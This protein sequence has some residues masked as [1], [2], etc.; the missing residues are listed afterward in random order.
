[1]CH[2]QEL[3]LLV[4][5]EG[6]TPTKKPCGIRKRRKREVGT[7]SGCGDG[8][9]GD[10]QDGDGASAKKPCGRPKTG[11]VTKPPKVLGNT[12]S[13]LR[14]CNVMYQYDLRDGA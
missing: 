6:E 7:A 2:N 14:I 3:L 5:G 8:L 11:K 9:Q 4:P 13:E 1:M 12:K 10:G